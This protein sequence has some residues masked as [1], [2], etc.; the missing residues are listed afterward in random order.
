MSARDEAHAEAL[1]AIHEALTAA[2]V[3]LNG[4]RCAECRRG[5]DR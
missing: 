2:L 3:P 5:A 4:P 1:D